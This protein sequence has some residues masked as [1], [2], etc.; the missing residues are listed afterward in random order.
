[1]HSHKSPSSELITDTDLCT[2]ML[3]QPLTKFKT[4]TITS[5]SY[6]SVWDC[7]ERTLVIMTRKQFK[8]MGEKLKLN[9]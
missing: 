2:L 6:V 1:M 5:D 4:Y 3:Y 9:D 8:K 7:E